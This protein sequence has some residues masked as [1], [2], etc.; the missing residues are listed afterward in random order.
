MKPIIILGTGG[1]CIDILDTINEINSCSPARTYN[2]VGFLDDDQQN[3]GKE[4]FGVKVLGPLESAYDF[5]N[6]YFVN[7]IGSPFNFWLKDKIIARTGIPVDKFETIVHPTASVS[8]MSKIGLGTVIL[9]HV[10]IASNVIIGNHVIVLPNSVISHDSSIG[11][12]T[13]ITGGVCVS[14]GTKIGRSCYLGTNSSVLGNTTVGDN[15]LI[16]MGSV[17]LGDVETNSAVVG[18]PAAFL[19]KVVDNQ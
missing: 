19:R 1:N 12:Y 6:C 10:T 18:S 4:I 15:C 16:G 5:P 2:C 14:G 8:K 17:V 11:D 13:C 7:G 3:W 9:Q